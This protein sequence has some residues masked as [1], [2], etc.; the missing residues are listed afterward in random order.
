VYENGRFTAETFPVPPITMRRRAG[1]RVVTL[2]RAIVR[3][4]PRH[5]L[6]SYMTSRPA[7]PHDA[8]EAL[9]VDA[10][11]NVLEGTTT[12]VF[13]VA[14]DTLITASEGI[15]PGIMRAVVLAE[16][17]RVIERPPTIEEL[18]AGSFLTS[19]LTLIAPIV[20]VNGVRSAG[21]PVLFADAP[22]GSHPRSDPHG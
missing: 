8:E 13:A 5:K 17:K 14:G 16:A 19:S 6:V 3:E 12:N 9:F 2:D 15:L 4:Q 18:L 22:R 10:K 7:I 11:G 20:S 1:A 21:V